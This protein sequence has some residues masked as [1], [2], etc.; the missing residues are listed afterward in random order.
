MKKHLSKILLAAFA[1]MLLSMSVLVGCGGGTPDS[2]EGTRW[3]PDSVTYNGQTLD[4]SQYAQIV[5]IP[6]S[7]MSIDFKDGKVIFGGVYTSSD[8][9]TYE[10][11]K[12]SFRGVTFDVKGDSMELEEDGVIFHYK[13]K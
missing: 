1:V 2:L 5:E 13:K 9:Y 12:V 6:A 10:N 3:E 4:I 8:D 7:D 11:G